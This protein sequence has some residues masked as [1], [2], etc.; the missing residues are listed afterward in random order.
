MRTA[1]AVAFAAVLVATAGSAAADSCYDPACRD[2]RER[3]WTKPRF[4][5]GFGMLAGSYTVATVGGTAI[6]M[7]MDAGVRLHRWA[8]LGEYDFLSIG[9]S[10]YEVDDPIRGQLHRLGANARY[11]LAAFGGRDVPIRGDFWV[12]GGVGNQLV[13]WNGGGELSRR[14]LALG[15]G[16]QM[17]VRIGRDKPSYLGFY[18]AFRGLVARDP[19]EGKG[20]PTCAGPCDTA[21]GPSPWDIGAF[22]NFGLV[23]SR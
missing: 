8:L 14:D 19:F 22:F 1:A 3:A 21:T 12:E 18:Y 16:G 6:G 11:S 7:H 5:G 15:A 20:M 4:E 9:Q 13:I 10:A 23:F 17:T 2:E